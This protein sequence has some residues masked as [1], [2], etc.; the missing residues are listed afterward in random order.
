MSN[1]VL[2]ILTSVAGDASVS[3]SLSNQFVEALKTT[4]ADVVSRN[5]VT[6]EIPHF[7]HETLATLGAGEKTIGDTLIEEIQAAD[8]IVISAPMY[9]FH[10]P[11]QLK[12]W[13]DHIARAGVTFQY[14]ANGPEGLLKGKKAVVITTRGGVYKNTASDSQ[15]PFIQTMLGFVGI[16]DVEVIYAEGL[17][18][19]DAR[20]ANL[21]Q[22]QT[23]IDSLA[24]A[25]A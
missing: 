12:S 1:N 14:G 8:T 22:A 6:D 18:M 2:Q 16:I 24:S 21:A 9:N 15:I 13:F 7:S 25:F 20:E 5:V 3:A 23:D 11:S 4:G 19:R 17:A 10:I